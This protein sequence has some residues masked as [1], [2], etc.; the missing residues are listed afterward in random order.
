MPRVAVEAVVVS[1]SNWTR[2]AD[3]VFDYPGPDGRWLRDRRVV[4]VLGIVLMIGGAAVILFGLSS[5][6]MFIGPVLR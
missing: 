3:V 1:Y 6:L 5:T 4:G 2:P